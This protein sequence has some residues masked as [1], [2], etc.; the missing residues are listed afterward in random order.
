MATRQPKS[1]GLNIENMMDDIDKQ[2]E[3]NKEIIDLREQLEMIHCACKE[4]KYSIQMVDLAVKTI[5]DTANRLDR[6]SEIYNRILDEIKESIGRVHNV[7]F[8]ASLDDNSVTAIKNE[9][10]SFINNQKKAL[11]ETDR[12]LRDH[13][14]VFNYELSN[15]LNNKGFWCSSKTFKW[16]CG[17]F[18]ASISIIVAEIT[19]LIAITLGK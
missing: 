8:T 7:E 12:I 16:L 17:I 13:L 10:D 11:N 9:Y 1:S 5:N 2:E 18:L 19:L 3:V 4:Q 14:S 6:L 15:V